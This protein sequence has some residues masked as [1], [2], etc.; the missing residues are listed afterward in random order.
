ML[1]NITLKEVFIYFIV[2][3]TNVVFDFT[4]VARLY[5]SLNYCIKDVTKHLYY[6]FFKFYKIKYSFIVL[7]PLVQYKSLSS[8]AIHCS[9]CSLF[10]T[11]HFSLYPHLP[12]PQYFQRRPQQLCLPVVHTAGRLHALQCLQA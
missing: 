3:Y 2:I 4:N 5:C 1:K 11:L 12:T 10:S 8:S 6:I 7:T 9:P